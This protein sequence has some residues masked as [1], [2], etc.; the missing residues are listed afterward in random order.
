M[1]FIWN[2]V[3]IEAIDLD[4]AIPGPHAKEIAR[5]LEPG[6]LRGYLEG[7]RV[8]VGFQEIRS[9]GKVGKGYRLIRSLMTMT[10]YDVPT[11]APWRYAMYL[12]EKMLEQATATTGED[13]Q[14]TASP[15]ET[16]EAPP[17]LELSEPTPQ[18]TAP[19]VG[20]IGDDALQPI[21][22]EVEPKANDAPQPT[23]AEVA[24]KAEDAQLTTPEGEA[25][26]EDAQIT[27]PEVVLRGDDAPQPTAPEVETKA[28]EAQLT[29]PG[30]ETSTDEDHR[31]TDENEPLELREEADMPNK[32]EKK[33]RKK[34]RKNR[35]RNPGSGEQHNTPCQ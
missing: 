26:A 28:E 9:K 1:I 20:P 33:H 21:M 34:R 29:T 18:P 17:E 6:Y 24:P 15:V 35:R 25:K 8:A 16:S 30:V 23:A 4:K 22:P 2:G 10:H 14:L 32:G 7:R 11:E 19:E 5:H 13:A 27:T 3:E 31:S 12:K